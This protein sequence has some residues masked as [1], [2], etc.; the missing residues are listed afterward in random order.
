MTAGGIKSSNTLDELESHLRD[1]TERQLQ[2]GTSEEAAF[3]SALRQMGRAEL[4]KREFRKISRGSIAL[5]RF[6]IGLGIVFIGF[7]IFLSAVTIVLC[8]SGWG[9]RLMAS[10]AVAGTLLV[11]CGWRYALPFLPVIGA[12][13]KRWA[14][15]LVCIAGGIGACCFYVS[16]ILPLFEPGPDR[17]LPAIGLWAIFI[18]AF[19]SCLGLGLILGERQRERLGMHR[20]HL[21]HT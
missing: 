3:G 8:L 11:A 14:A 15:G 21:P 13:R 5:E 4:L 1:E 2:H 10:A 12:A 18:L 6:M 7:G 17:P 9:D 16:V 19:S 20:D